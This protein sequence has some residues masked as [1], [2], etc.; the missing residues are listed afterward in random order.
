MDLSLRGYVTAV[1]RSQPAGELPR[2]VEEL[3]QVAR[4]IRG[5][6]ELAAALSDVAV[7]TA[8][9]RA[10]VQELFGPRVLPPVLR[11]LLH[12]VEIERPPDLLSALHDTD[13]LARLRLDHPAEADLADD[14]PMGRTAVRRL[15]GGMAAAELEPVESAEDIREIEDQL[16]RFARVVA[17]Q[18][19]LAAAL[20]DWSVPAEHRAELVVTLLGGKARPEA[21]RLAAAAVRLRTRDVVT[22]LDWLAEVAAAARGWRVARVQAAME[23]DADERQR[24]AEALG[25]LT[26]Q[27][28]ELDVQVDP[29]L[30][31]GARVEIGDLLVDATTRHRLDQLQEQ[32][33]SPE[34][35][36][37][38]LLDGTGPE[39][40][41]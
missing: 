21:V 10:V 18:P 39:R 9:R 15:L 25:H 37:R 19:A 2:L 16:F 31:G 4:A 26:G 28:V 32:L 6:T 30:L 11:V 17:A 20:A 41:R 12:A 35:A 36:T 22:V 7:P 34:G 8:A 27:P 33:A 5:T 23:I 3:G 29:S 38:A 13:E 1:L 24:L 40:Q 14:R